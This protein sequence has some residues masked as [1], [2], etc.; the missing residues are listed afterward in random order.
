MKFAALIALS[1]TACGIASTNKQAKDILSRQLEAYSQSGDAFIRLDDASYKSLILDKP[2][3]YHVFVI[4]T[5]NYNMCRICKPF[6]DAL[7]H[8]ALSY[9]KVPVCV[10][11]HLPYRRESMNSGS[12]L[13][14]YSSPPWTYLL[15]R[16]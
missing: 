4:Y 8:V 11:I 7:E 3:K 5:A 10:S 14:Q 12:S 13:T 2:K 1:L 16:R 9:F 6:F 15:I